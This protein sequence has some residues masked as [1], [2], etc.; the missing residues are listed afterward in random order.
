MEG[1][2]THFACSF[3]DGDICG[4]LFFPLGFYLLLGML[5]ST[6]NFVSGIALHNFAPLTFFALVI[7]S[8][9]MRHAVPLAHVTLP[10]FHLPD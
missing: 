3:L 1:K 6:G 8:A 2:K 5:P 4:F 7:L 9:A 10:V